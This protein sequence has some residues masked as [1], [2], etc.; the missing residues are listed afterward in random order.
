MSIDPALVDLRARLESGG[1]IVVQEPE[2]LSVRLPYFCS[3]QIR[4][5]RGRLR[6]D[7]FFGVVP[8]TRATLL[9]LIGTTSVAVSTVLTMGLAPL[10]VALGFLVVASAAYDVIRTI[11]TE[12]VITRVQTIWALNATAERD[13]HH[14]S[15]AHAGL[16]NSPL[17]E[18]SIRMNAR[19]EIRRDT[20]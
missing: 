20:Q 1:M 14:L 7:P 19:A 17:A 5:E 4:C 11:L 16:L 15:D 8:R 9:K 10:P 18:R 2:Y 3:V 13:V 12:N 6:C